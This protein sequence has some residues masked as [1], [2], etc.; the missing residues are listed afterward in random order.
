MNRVKPVL[1]FLKKCL[2]FPPVWFCAYLFLA[3]HSL[4]FFVGNGYSVGT[5]SHLNG[6]VSAQKSLLNVLIKDRPKDQVIT[7]VE[8]VL[9]R[10]EH[11]KIKLKV[12]DKAII[13][14]NTT[15]YF[16]DDKVTS[17]E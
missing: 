5:I 6:V 9:S 15:I 7:S 3:Y 14:G 1:M 2:L 10:P 4:D 8:N 16:T 12:T 13:F 17:I 11:S